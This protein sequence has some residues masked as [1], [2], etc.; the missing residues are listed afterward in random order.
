VLGGLKPLSTS[1][2]SSWSEAFP[3]T[4]KLTNQPFHN[5]CGINPNILY[6]LKLKRL[7]DYADP[8]SWILAIIELWKIQ[9]NKFLDNRIRRMIWVLPTQF[10]E[11]DP[12]PP[13]SCGKYFFMKRKLWTWLITPPFTS[14]CVRVHNVTIHG[15]HWARTIPFPNT[16]FKDPPWLDLIPNCYKLLMMSA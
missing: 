6:M 5:Q 16:P 10:L 1:K 12:S 13:P 14:S 2:A 8:T 9:F 15:P 3:H 7:F 4:Y 11:D